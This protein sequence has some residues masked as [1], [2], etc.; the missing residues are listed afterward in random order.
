MTLLKPEHF[1]FSKLA[2]F[3]DPDFVQ[4]PIY[5]RAWWPD[6]PNDLARLWPVALWPWYK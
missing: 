4:W 2:Y 5:R 3:L 1:V 6:G